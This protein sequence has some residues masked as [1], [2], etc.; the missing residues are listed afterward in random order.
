MPT[1]WS[2]VIAE[3][4][5]LGAGPHIVAVASKRA[6]GGSSSGE[7]SRCRATAAPP[8]RPAGGTGGVGRERHPREVDAQELGIGLAVGGSIETA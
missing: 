1:R 7:R 5:A 4:G 3:T 8:G 6:R 2:R